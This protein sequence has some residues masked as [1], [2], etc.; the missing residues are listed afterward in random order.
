[1]RPREGSCGVTNLVLVAFVLFFQVVQT[2]LFPLSKT[3]SN[4]A[5]LLRFSSLVF[6]SKC[7]LKRTLVPNELVVLLLCQV[8]GCQQIVLKTR[9]KY[10]QHRLKIKS[11]ILV[12]YQLFFESLL[13]SLDLVVGAEVA[14]V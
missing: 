10:S 11:T 9:P 4:R 1:M 14:V 6:A 8:A 7:F 13:V 3:R 5:D 2:F 12:A